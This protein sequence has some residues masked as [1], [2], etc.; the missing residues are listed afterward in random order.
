M[1]FPVHLELAIKELEVV[2]HFETR[3]DVEICLAVGPVFLRNV[4]SYIR[5]MEVVFMGSQVFKTLG[6]DPLAQLEQQQVQERQTIC[7]DRQ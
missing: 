5:E 1:D 4:P 7:P 3:V 2:Y 6:I